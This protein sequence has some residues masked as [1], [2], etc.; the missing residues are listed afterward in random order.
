MPG[1]VCPDVAPPGGTA[2]HAALAMPS[3]RFD[4][5][6]DAPQDWPLFMGKKRKE[7]QRLNGV[8][9]NLLSNA[10]V[11]VRGWGARGSEPGTWPCRCRVRVDGSPPASPAGWRG[12]LAGRCS[13]PGNDSPPARGPPINTPQF[14]EGRGKIVDAHTVEVD[15]QRFTAKNILVATGARAFVPDFPGSE[16]CIIS[17]HVLE[18]DEV[19]LGGGG[20]V[21]G[22]LHGSV[23]GTTPGTRPPGP[24]RVPR[25]HEGTAP[26][27]H[28]EAL[29]P[30][31]PARAAGH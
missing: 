18:L 24:A 20:W 19:W 26:L 10:G 4:V 21:E 17:D 16:H 28:D 11:K 27:A 12:R 6:P 13:L 2:P 22:W 25:T 1:A 7:L 15:G 29:D 14:I 31:P 3:S 23:T 8:Y 9:L 5:N 30:P